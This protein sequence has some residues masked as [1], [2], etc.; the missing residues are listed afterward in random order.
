MPIRLTFLVRF[1]SAPMS[2][3]VPQTKVIFRPVGGNLALGDGV[4]SSPPRTGGDEPSPAI[5]ADRP[6]R[7]QQPDHEYGEDDLLLNIR[8][9]EPAGLV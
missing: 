8:R 3:L 6:D 4:V 1:R 9:E 7:D 5:R 2:M